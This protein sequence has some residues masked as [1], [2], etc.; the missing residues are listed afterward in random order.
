M[1]WGED[2]R[3]G[4]EI[5]RELREFIRGQGFA[6]HVPMI[7]RAADRVHS[8]ALECERLERENGLWREL[9]ALSPDD[10]VRAGRIRR[11]LGIKSIV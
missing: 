2:R 4:R 7:E 3:T 6:S 11:E 9:Q 1:N 8:L 10:I 5:A